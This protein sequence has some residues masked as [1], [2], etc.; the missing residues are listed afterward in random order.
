MKLEA[1]IKE[2]DELLMEGHLKE[3]LQKLQNCLNTKNDKILDN[4]YI[5]LRKGQCHYMMGDM[6]E[7]AMEL[8]IAYTLDGERIFED[9]DPRFLAF[10]KERVSGASDSEN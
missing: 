7:A 6:E 3:A 2:A 4:P 8:S 1:R 5:H 10:L 9:E